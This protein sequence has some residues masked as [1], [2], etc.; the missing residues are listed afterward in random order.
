MMRVH[1]VANKI[2]SV[3]CRYTSIL[4][5]SA[6]GARPILGI[7]REIGAGKT[8]W[9]GTAEI[10]L[11]IGFCMSFWLDPNVSHYFESARFFSASLRS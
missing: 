7:P 9:T 1:R 5:C 10:T 8:R 11:L 6:H 4:R 2:L 3:D